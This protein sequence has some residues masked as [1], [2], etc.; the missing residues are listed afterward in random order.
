MIKNQSRLLPFLDN[1]FFLFLE[2]LIS[3]HVVHSPFD[4]CAL[5]HDPTT[6]D[7]ISIS[8]KAVFVS[9]SSILLLLFSGRHCL[10]LLPFSALY[11]KKNSNYRCN[12][13]FFLLSMAKDDRLFYFLL[14]S[15][16]YKRTSNCS[17]QLHFKEYVRTFDFVPTVHHHYMMTITIVMLV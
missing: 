3:I 11:L 6:C 14:I 4:E 16:N 5:Q 13:N 7:L 10:S 12:N 9:F 17:I 15:V 8:S 2:V 1:R